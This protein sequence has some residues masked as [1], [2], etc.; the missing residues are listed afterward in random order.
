MNKYL[1]G[2]R[3]RFRPSFILWL[4]IMWCLLM[5]EFTWANVFG[6]MLVG[7]GIVFF[8]PLPAMPISELNVSW[9]RL[10][11]YMFIWTGELLWA[12]VKV[13]WIAIRPGEKPKNAILRG[14]MRVENELVLSFAVVLYNLQPGGTVA[15]IDIANRMLT[16][17][18]LDA[19]TQA[20]IDREVANLVSLE[21][22]MI[23]IFEGK[24]K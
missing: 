4:T 10:I 12:S 20:D 19:T 17:H 22:R 8:L 18:V 23:S 11:R 6:G 1:T 9:G 15:E 13:G 3:H 2:A 14:P 7:L 24:H 5:G 21:R 16:V